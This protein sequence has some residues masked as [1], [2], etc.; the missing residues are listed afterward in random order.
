MRTPATI[1]CASMGCS[2]GKLGCTS[3][4]SPELLVLP[5]I[6]QGLSVIDD[7]IRFVS[8]EVFPSILDGSDSED[9]TDGNHAHR[10]LECID[11]GDEIQNDDAH[12]IEIGKAVQLLKKVL[13][14][15][16]QHC[17]LAGLDLVP[18]VVAVRV[19]FVGPS[20]ERQVGDHDPLLIFF[21]FPPFPP[22]LLHLC[23]S[24]PLL[25]S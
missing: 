6:D 9:D 22:F 17:V 15:E 13:G 11:H 24:L 10:W 1:L 2:Q 25:L 12:K 3:E 23:L 14:Y 7:F 18:T 8:P 16:G 21:L 5:A 4:T 19:F 20:F